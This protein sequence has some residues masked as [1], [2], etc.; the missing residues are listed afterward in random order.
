M[1]PRSLRKATPAVGHEWEK[2]Q[3]ARRT[4]LFNVWP[5]SC[6]SA[7]SPITLPRLLARPRSLARGP[8]AT[9]LACLSD[10]LLE[11]RGQVRPAP[12]AILAVDHVLLHPSYGGVQSHHPGWNGP[13]QA[14]SSNP[15]EWNRH[16]STVPH[17]RLLCAAVAAP[18]HGTPG[19]RPHPTNYP[20]VLQGW[21][22]TCWPARFD[23]SASLRRPSVTDAFVLRRPCQAQSA[24]AVARPGHDALSI[25][26]PLSAPEMAVIV[27]G[28]G[29]SSSTA[30]AVYRVHAARP[31]GRSTAAA[32]APAK[33][34][35]RDEATGRMGGENARGLDGARHRQTSAPPYTRTRLPSTRIR[36]LEGRLA[37][38]DLRA[39]GGTAG[40]LVTLEPAGRPWHHWPGPVRHASPRPR[41]RLA[42]QRLARRRGRSG[43]LPCARTAAGRGR[44]EE[45]GAFSTR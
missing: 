37:Q 5:S 44:A 34:E 28:R 41:P 21:L 4:C 1:I 11:R 22:A 19:L 38:N 17:V 35:R 43:R 10:R 42:R 7:Q 29:P 30:V 39:R 27:G 32:A 6:L 8:R 36:S 26:W 25:F 24:S 15:D 45:G 20:V 33:V 14:G 31:Q 9:G 18:W 12:G 40:G 16:A 2:K 13:L 23:P 3:A